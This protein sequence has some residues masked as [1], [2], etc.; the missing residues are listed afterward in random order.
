[1]TANSHEDQRGLVSTGL[2][3]P[4][5]RKTLNENLAQ[6]FGRKNLGALVQIAELVTVRVYAVPEMAGCCIQTWASTVAPMSSS[7][8]LPPNA[9]LADV[10]LRLNYLPRV[11]FGSCFTPDMQQY[12]RTI[13]RDCVVEV[14]TRRFYLRS[15][16]SPKAPKNPALLALCE[17]TKTKAWRGEI[18]IL[19]LGSRFC[20]FRKNIKA[21]EA[22]KAV[23]GWAF[24][25]CLDL[26]SQYSVQVH[27]NAPPV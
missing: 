18:A 17:K 15:S 12:S 4:M 16:F 7:L 6:H 25:F 1:M 24:P 8:R 21:I 19:E 13:I 5:A 9:A 2:N 20:T 11:D 10:S 23:V 22:D 26:H 3:T 14:G 27:E